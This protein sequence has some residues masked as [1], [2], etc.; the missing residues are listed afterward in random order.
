MKMLLVF[1]GTELIKQIQYKTK[2]IAKK[3]LSLFNKHGM[4][5]PETG[6]TVKG[7]TF[8]LI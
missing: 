5:D 7:L 6:E 4:I 8:E 3:H 2:A 1:K